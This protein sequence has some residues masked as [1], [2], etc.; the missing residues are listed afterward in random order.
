MDMSGSVVFTAI[1]AISGGQLTADFGDKQICY[2]KDAHGN[3]HR[4]RGIL[5]MNM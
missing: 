2:V 5:G 3:H 4:E 1:L